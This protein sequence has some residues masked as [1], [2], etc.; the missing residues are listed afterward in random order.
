VEPKDYLDRFLVDRG[1]GYRLTRGKAFI[2]FVPLSHFR[3]GIRRRRGGVPIL[4]RH[5]KSG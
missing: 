4:K 1:V 5:F 2:P 3:V